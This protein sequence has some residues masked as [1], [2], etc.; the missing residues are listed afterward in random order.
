M[1]SQRWER[2]DAEDRLRLARPI[3][4]LRRYPPNRQTPPPT[5]ASTCS[6]RST[7]RR[8]F[9]FMPTAS[10]RSAPGEDA[11]LASVPGGACGPRHLSTTSATAHN[12]EMR[13]VLEE[14][15]THGAAVDAATLAGDRAVHEALLDQHRALQQ[16]HGAQVRPEVHAR[17]RSRRRRTR[18]R[19]AGARF[20]RARRNARRDAR[21]HAAAVLRCERRPDR[22]EQ[23]ARPGQGH[24]CWRAPTIST[25]ASR[26]PISRG[27]KERYAL[28]SRLVKG[29]GKLVEE[30]YRIGGKIRPIRSAR[31]VD[32]SRG[33][34]S[35]RDRADGALRSKRSSHSIGR[36]KTPIAR[37]YDIAW[38][39]DKDSPVDTINGFIEVYMDPRGD[40]GLLGSARLLV[41]H[42]KTA[43]IQKLAAGGAVVRGSHAVGS[44][45]PKAGCALASPRKRSTSSS[46]R[47]IRAR[48]RRSASTC[49]TIRRSARSTAASRCRYPTSTRRTTSRRCRPSGRSSAGRRTKPRG[50]RVGAA[51]PDELHTNMHEVIGHASG[52]VTEQRRAATRK[53]CSRSTTRRSK[54]RAPISWRST[55]CPIRSSRSSASCPPR[56][57][58]RSS[59]AEYEATRATPSHSFVASARGRRSKKITCA[60]G[61]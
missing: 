40:E 19:T 23:D 55:S 29:D 43:D 16:P 52:K 14:I 7:K 58:R 50:R 20:P 57:S 48:S 13:D 53:A 17:R 38:V 21:P 6:N 35:V 5:T 32:A 59:S 39:Q 33:G 30:V 1:H 11:H 25:T 47:V 46:R 60:T 28:N 54:R 3:R 15:I 42:E 18:P 56:T 31:I 27:F 36:A 41:N 12:L 8:W 34:D 51:S 61:R 44:R 24:P 26:W 10:R 4:S 37:A 2:A 9:S 49:R 22:H 45:V